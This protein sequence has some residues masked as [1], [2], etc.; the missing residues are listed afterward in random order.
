MN[1]D[2]ANDLAREVAFNAVYLVQGADSYLN[3]M[4]RGGNAGM[5]DEI[6]GHMA[7]TELCAQKAVLVYDY[8]KT[9][10]KEQ[11]FPGVYAYEVTEVVG[12]WVAQNLNASDEEFVAKLKEVSAA[13]FAQSD[14]FHD[15]VFTVEVNGTVVYDTTDRP[16][17]LAFAKANPGAVFKQ[18][19]MELE[20][21]A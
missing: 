19:G 10:D 14:D 3:M 12:V 4:N 16:A 18:D 1:R 7:L 15:R 21:T 8:L 13:F 2:D 20:L 9:L 5:L 6:G 11:D 17:A